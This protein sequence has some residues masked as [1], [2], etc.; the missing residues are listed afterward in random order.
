MEEGVVLRR[1]LWFFAPSEQRSTVV[2][3][4]PSISIQQVERASEILVIATSFGIP[5]KISAYR[6]AD[7]MLGGNVLIT[8]I[9]GDAFIGERTLC[10]G[11]NAFPTIVGNTILFYYIEEHYLAQYHL[12]SGTFS[13][14]SDGSVIGYAIPSPCSIIFHI[15][16]CC[17]RQQWSVTCFFLFH[18][19]CP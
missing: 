9:D 11:S 18:H 3:M 13:P 14:A 1:A 15:N 17:Y 5:K 4:T 7:L 16:T 6:L 10:V 12:S 2:S 8:C 19:C